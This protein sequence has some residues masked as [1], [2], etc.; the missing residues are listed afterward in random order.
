VRRFLIS[1]A[2]LTSR[3]RTPTVA[4][5]GY[6]QIKE[7]ESIFEKR[8]LRG[9]AILLDTQCKHYSPFV[10]RYSIDPVDTPDRMPVPIGSFISKHVY[11]GNLKT[12][13]PLISPKTCRFIDVRN[14]EEEKRG[15]SWV[16]SHNSYFRCVSVAYQVTSLL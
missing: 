9:N 1:L 15:H 13:H 7:L 11:G 2:L 10:R 5:Y 3:F 4:P 8:H 14:S 6:E 16:V 12:N